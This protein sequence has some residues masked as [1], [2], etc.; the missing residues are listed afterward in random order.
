MAKIL[1]TGGTGCIGS[2][3][4]YK[5]LQYPTVEKI[6]V[7][8]RSTNKEPVKLW[9]GENIDPRVEFVTFDLSDYALVERMVP[10]INPTHII[11]LGGFQ[12]PDCAANHL[13][14]MEINVGG[15]MALLDVAEKLCGL[16]RLVFASSGAVYG[17][18]SMYPG[19]TI[20]E[21][22]ILT[23]PNHYGIWKLAG[24][25]LA[26]FF[27]D[28]TNVPTVCLRLNT[29]YGL[30]RDKGMTSAPT[31]ALKAIA[32]GVFND[33][34]IPFAMPYQGLENYHF[35]EDVGEHFAACTMQPFSGYGFFN[36]RGKTIEVKQFLDIV[37]QEA[38]ALGWGQYTDISIA[39]DA[40][41][42]LFSHSLCHEKIEKTFKDMPLTPVN[43]GVRRSLIAFHKI[44]GK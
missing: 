15:T 38:A 34:V 20:G 13:K 22:V 17:Q 42:N 41:P 35:V 2:V 21:N 25:H 27:H 9:L 36:I 28:R 43:E 5:L 8:T 33:K 4:I 6:V 37:R 24:E 29:T 1:I 23:P 31:A 16:E 18:R 26:R 44:N 40:Q 32:F 14:G 19:A 39:P 12:S 7:A 3:T 11:H 30:G 10:Q